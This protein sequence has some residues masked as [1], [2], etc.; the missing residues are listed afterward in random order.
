MSGFCPQCGKP[1]EAGEAFCSQCGYKAENGGQRGGYA[2]PGSMPYN[3]PVQTAY[4]ASPYS[5]HAKGKLNLFIILSALFILLAGAVVALTFVFMPYN[6]GPKELN[7][8]WDMMLRL[9]SVP[10]EDAG[11]AN[12]SDIGK[13]RDMSM[14]LSLDRKGEGEA[15]INGLRF[16]A[17]YE[18]GKIA[19]KGMMDEKLQ[20]SLQGTLKKENKDLVFSGSWEYTIVKGSGKGVVAQGIWRAILVEPG[21]EAVSSGGFIQP[22][23]PASSQETA[24]DAGTLAADLEGTWKGMLVMETISG[25]EEN[26]N[27]SEEDKAYMLE[28]AGQEY[29]LVLVVRN[30]MF[31]LGDEYDLEYMTDEDMGSLT[32][33]GSS[34][35]GT[36][37]T[38]N[39]LAANLTGELV[40]DS[41]TPMVR[42]D[43]V[44]PDVPAYSSET[45]MVTVI[46]SFSG[47]KQ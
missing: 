44:F 42:C 32:I 13:E 33:S 40:S 16:G 21:E 22:E 4:A 9:D 46:A 5:A 3:P 43:V 29:E 34:F 18:N 37:E 27:I 31:W 26:P 25:L 12:A 19:V 15:T 47:I 8:N 41:G 11:Y 35:Y 1:M 45:E 10:N 24:A 17:A 2:P 38:A 14:L 7:G 36:V 6:A 28:E 23:T 30:G 20:I 39:G